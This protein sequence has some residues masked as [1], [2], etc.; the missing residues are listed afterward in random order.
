MSGTRHI[1]LSPCDIKGMRFRNRLAVAPMTRVTA[2]ED[3]LVTQAMRDYYLRFAKGGFG[4]IITEGLYTDKAFS[5]GYINQP[6]L[7]DKEQALSWSRLNQDLRAEGARVFAQIMHAGALSQGN[8]YRSHSVAPSAVQPVGEQMTVYHGKGPYRR[9]VEMTEAQIA[10][11][12]EGFAEAAARAV[13]I[14]GFDGIEIH[15]ANGYL[16][17]Q[18]LSAHTNVRDDRWGGDIG[19][20]MSLLVAVVKAVKQRV[21]P[22]VPV[23]IRISQG[24]VND[25]KHKWSGGEGDAGSVFTA[26][27]DA[28]VDFI[29]VTE[30]EAWKPAFEGSP[31]SLVALARRYAP[32]VPIIANGGLHD[33]DRASEVTGSGAD[34]VALG[35]GA[36]SNPDYPSL[37]EAGAPLRSFDASILQ[38]VADIKASELNAVLQV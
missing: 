3:G 19:Q 34:L 17:D 38:P 29:H 7:A 2:T 4:L 18:F 32:H 26:L 21:G 28:N 16:L 33:P 10:D 25:F 15:G 36:L 6:G 5:Q 35:R 23:G 22:T 27:A 9:P 14:A 20:R 24:K 11:A 30:Y 1:I 8:R 12:I 37:I 13:D 31:D